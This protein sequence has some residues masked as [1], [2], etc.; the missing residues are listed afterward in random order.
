MSDSDIKADLALAYH[1]LSYLRIDDHTYT[2]LSARPKGSN[3][4]YI[5]PFGF[6][7]EEVTPD[8]L[9]KVSLDGKVMEGEELEY[10]I[11]GYLTH[12]SIYRKR[13]DIGSI[14]HLHTHATIAVSSITE[15][16]MPI[17]QWALHLYNGISYAD[18]DSL[19]L[20]PNSGMQIAQSLKDNFVMLLRNHG[21]ITCGRDIQEAMFY[22]YH[23]EQACIAQ[24]QTLSMGKELVMPDKA[25]CAKAV[26]DILSFEPN[27]GHR[28]WKAW[29][30]KISALRS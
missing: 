7:F 6:M 1:I 17:N 28:D 3:Y 21:S 5:L 16:L 22:T 25:T 15:G 2:H 26:K 23:L 9:L 18:Y 11:T 12:S 4:F 20:G 29:K 27:L 13:P 19:V 14:F 30:R 24:I 8:N 10:N